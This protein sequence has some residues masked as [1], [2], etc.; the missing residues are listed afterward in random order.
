MLQKKQNTYLKAL[1]LLSLTSLALSGFIFPGKKVAILEED[2][3]VE[4][5]DPK[6]HRASAGVQIGRRLVIKLKGNMDS[7]KGW[8]LRD[9]SKA[10][11]DLL[12]PQNLNSFNAGEFICDQD[13]FGKI[14]NDGFHYFI[15]KPRKV[16]KVLLNFSYRR[17]F[18]WDSPKD[19]RFIVS[20]RV[21]RNAF[22]DTLDV[23]N[24]C[25]VKKINE[26]HERKKRAL[27]KPKVVANHA[28]RG[29]DHKY[30]G[31]RNDCEDVIDF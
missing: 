27:K 8:Y 31:I 16:G 26:K 4:I 17:P 14:Q 2:S 15:F 5:T 9:F 29:F 23:Y 22:D 18:R 25:D 10:S 6:L 7:G 3:V 13:N 1:I 11:R 28:F 30:K 24:D 19:E 12:A 21:M 20:V